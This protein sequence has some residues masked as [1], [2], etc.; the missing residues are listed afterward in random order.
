MTID[1]ATLAAKFLTPDMVGKVAGLIGEDSATTGSLLS[2]AVPLLLGS[3][4][5]GGSSTGIDALVAAIAPGAAASPAMLGSIGTILGDSG[6]TGNAIAAGSALFAS[7]FGLNSDAITRALAGSA[8][9]SAS[10]AGSVLGLATPMVGAVI[11]HALAEQN[12]PV[13]RENVLGLLA[14]SQPSSLAA[15]PLPL[16]TVLGTASVTF[17]QGEQRLAIIDTP[18]QS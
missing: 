3:I 18:L 1:L 9:S 16:R 12:K 6:A 7:L 10:A 11:G 15:L 17:K 14:D 2:G 5:S 8:R 4:G 13:T